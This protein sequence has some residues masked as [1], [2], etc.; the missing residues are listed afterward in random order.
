[1]KENCLQLLNN[2]TLDFYFPANSNDQILEVGSLL[3]KE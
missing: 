1:M 3:L 2:D